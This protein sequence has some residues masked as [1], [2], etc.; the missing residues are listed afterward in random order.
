MWDIRTCKHAKGSVCE[1]LSKLD[2]Q[3]SIR[4]GI[5]SSSQFLQN[6]LIE[7]SDICFKIF[8]IADVVL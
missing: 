6:I 1:T 5:Y 3:D 7:T 8:Q 4:F 2:C